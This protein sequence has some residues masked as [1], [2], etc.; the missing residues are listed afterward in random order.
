MSGWLDYVRLPGESIAARQ[1][2]SGGVTSGFDYLRI[3]LAV[4]VVIEHSLVVT[5]QTLTA[6]LWT[7]WPRGALATILPAFFTLSG[8]L[9]AGSLQR[10]SSLPAFISMRIIRLVPALTV[11]VILSALIIGPL[12][13]QVSLATYFSSTEFWKYFLNII[14]DVQYVLPGMFAQNPFPDVMNQS[15]WTV[16]FELDCYLCLIGL[17]II[18]FVRNPRWLVLVTLGFAALGT[19]WLVVRFQPVWQENPVTGRALVVSFLAGVVLQLYSGVIKLNGPAALIS[20][21]VGM[22]L[23]LD[24]RLSFIAV[25]PIAYAT[26]YVGM[27]NPRR[28]SLLLSGDY[29]YGLYLFAFPIQQAEVAFFPAYAWWG[30]NAVVALACGFAYAA[31]SWWFVEAPILSRKR[32]A[33]AFADRLW[34]RVWNRPTTAKGRLRQTP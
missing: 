25:L 1:E 21:I 3:F 22:V 2:R 29:S 13:T 4:S 20:F 26:V 28:I 27:L 5:D 30:Y 18:G 8:F 19:V 24:V 11:E 7:T 32:E 6:N 34:A 14:G 31:L 10:R 12:L 15:L 23:L 33:A 17:A 9:V 16:P